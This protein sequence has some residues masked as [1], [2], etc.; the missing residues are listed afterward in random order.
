MHS[1]AMLDEWREYGPGR[2]RVPGRFPWS[3]RIKES[4]MFSV[5]KKKIE[6]G[7]RNG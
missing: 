3:G 6:R 1:E 2:R 5:N 7:N 4:Q